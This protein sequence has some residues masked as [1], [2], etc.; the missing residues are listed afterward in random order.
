MNSSNKQHKKKKKLLEI[1][2]CRTKFIHLLCGKK[3]EKK[4]TWKIN[5]NTA[6]EKKTILKTTLIS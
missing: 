5:K 1:S 2:S 3:A 4:I 6:K